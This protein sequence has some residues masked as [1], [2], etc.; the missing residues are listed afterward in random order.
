MPD[1]EIRYE[2]NVPF[3]WVPQLQQ[4]VREGAK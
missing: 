1:E 2:L 3:V 4:W